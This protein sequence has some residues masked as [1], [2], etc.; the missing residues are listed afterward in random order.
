M[1]RNH[2]KKK[3]S[4]KHHG[5]KQW[6]KTKVEQKDVDLKIEQ[7]QIISHPRG[8]S[9]TVDDGLEK[10]KFTCKFTSRVDIDNYMCRGD[11]ES[12][13]LKLNVF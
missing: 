3:K 12:S 1:V 4:I 5:W 6:F 11:G 10:N 8:D 7:K 13:P 2:V 9:T